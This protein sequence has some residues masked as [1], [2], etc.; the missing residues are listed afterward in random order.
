MG[1]TNYGWF[2]L[3]KRFDQN[4]YVLGSHETQLSPKL[5]EAKFPSF[6]SLATHGSS[7]CSSAS[8]CCFKGD[9][10]LLASTTAPVTSELQARILHLNLFITSAT[11]PK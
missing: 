10:K 2:F 8:L 5:E 1:K 9:D 3:R 11:E 4:S 7:L 6:H